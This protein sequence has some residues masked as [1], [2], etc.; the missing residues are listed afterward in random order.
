[1]SVFH[2]PL[3]T[4]VVLLMIGGV[5]LAV[6]GALAAVSHSQEINAVAF[7]AVAV[8]LV[9]AA[10]LV[11]RGVRW[12]VAVCFVVL[13]GQLAAI[14]GTVW[15]LTH[16]VAEIKAGQLRAL[17]FDPTISVAINLVYSSVGFGL[18]CWLALRWWFQ[19]R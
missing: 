10:V 7:V 1:M 12:A 3:K 2:R 11:A 14:V 19:R 15:E 8:V 4:G 9:A 16:G 18:F 5:A 6:T 17:G 13:A